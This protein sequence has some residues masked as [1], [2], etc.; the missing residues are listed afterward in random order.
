MKKFWNSKWTFTLV[1]SFIGTL[2]TVFVDWLKKKNIFSTL[3]LV[4]KTL[5][6]WLR[7][8]LDYEIKVW[9]ILVALGVLAIVILIVGKIVA[10]KDRTLPEWM[11]YTEDYFVDWKW[12]WTWEKGYDGKYR[13]ENLTAHCPKCDTPMRHDY[14]DTL[15]HC[16]RCHYESNRHKDN[17]ED[18]V[19]TI[20]DNIKRKEKA[21]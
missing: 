8:F 19:V 21:V 10:S 20:L 18:V 16:S 6:K 5:W 14:Y 12:S 3:K 1:T 15:F 17:R 9:W 7:A 2:F 4:L 13:V 11:N